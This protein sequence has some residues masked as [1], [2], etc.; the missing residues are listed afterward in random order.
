MDDEIIS[1]LVQMRENEGE[2]KIKD[3]ELEQCIK[4]RREDSDALYNF[5]NKKVHPEIRDKLILLVEAYFDDCVDYTYI[6]KKIYYK[7]GFSDGIKIILANL[8]D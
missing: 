5:I 6:K 7:A 1:A 2:L 3:E 8:K 4:Q